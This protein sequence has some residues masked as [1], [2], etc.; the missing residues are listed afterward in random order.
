M[1]EKKKINAKEIAED[2]RT[3][4]TDSDLMNKYGL[5]QKGLESIFLKLIKAEIMMESELES[6]VPA[7]TVDTAEL[8]RLRRIPRCYP[9][10]SIWIY[11]M[12]DLETEFE[13]ADI[14]EKG[15]QILGIKACIPDERT[16]S[17]RTED[18][19]PNTVLS[20]KAICRWV[21]EDDDPL[22]SRAGFEI[23]E[24]SEDDLKALRML[25]GTLSICDH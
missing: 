15:M 25:I 22:C 4:K 24:I 11:D 17:I 1:T 14:N 16:F 19:N 18:T 5:S 10:T 13:I 21:R 20:F 12:E 2:I 8:E 9:I 6:R 3:G 7:G 23:I